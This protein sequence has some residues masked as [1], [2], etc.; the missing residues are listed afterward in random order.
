MPSTPERPDAAAWLSRLGGK[1]LPAPAPPAAGAR[2]ATVPARGAAGR[3]HDRRNG[4]MLRT[5]LVVVGSAATAMAIVSAAAPV[6]GE[7]SAAAAIGACAWTC[8]LL[9]QRGHYRPAAGITVAGSMLLVGLSYQAYGLQ[10]QTGL[11]MTHLMPLLFAGLLL[12]RRAVWW[13]ALG[14]AGALVLGAMADA[15]RGAGPAPAAWVTAD[16]LLAALNVLVLAVILDRLIAISQKAI[17]RSEAL[18][19]ACA[20]LE[21]EI[22]EK[23]RAYARLLHTQRMEAIGRLSAGVAHDFNNILSVIL[24][25][26]GTSTAGGGAGFDG[27]RKAARRGAMLTRRLL[28]FGRTQVGEISRFDL[29]EAIEDM[30]PLLVPMFPRNVEVRLEAASGR[31]PVELDREELELALLNIASNA[32]DAMPD[33]GR[34]ELSVHACGADAVIRVA[35]TGIGMAPEV[36]SRVFEPFFT[37]KPRDSGTGIGMSIVHRFVTDAGG[38]I[39]LESAPGEGTRLEVR[40]PLASAAGIDR[41]PRRRTLLVTADIALSRSL[42]RALAAQ[43]C[44]V[45]AVESAD[46]AISRVLRSAS[47]DLVVASGRLPDGDGLMLLRQIGAVVPGAAQV[48]LLDRD[49]RMPDTPGIVALAPPFSPERLAGALGGRDPAADPAPEH[50]ALA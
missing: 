17:R 43:G 20:E 39:E 2:R 14:Y 35:D 11:Q 49:S 8:F 50:G 31:L 38:G 23:E 46:D 30:R 22:A 48:L 10:A 16:L 28:S 3:S 27:I 13:T 7:F 41:A 37:T 4:L 44:E 12:G 34:F 15:G 24:G 47:F 5:I 36:A 1:L 45:V 42:G 19:E 9:L 6:T 21:H 33:G 29:A 25:H 32:C 40:L 18:D 26:A